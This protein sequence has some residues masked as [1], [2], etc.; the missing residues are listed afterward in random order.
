MFSKSSLYLA[1]DS[2]SSFSSPFSL[3]AFVRFERRTSGFAGLRTKAS[4]PM[5]RASTA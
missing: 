2:F 5:L 1:S 4:A 3:R